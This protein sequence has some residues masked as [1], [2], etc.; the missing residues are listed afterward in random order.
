[1]DQQALRVGNLLVGNS[2]K[3]A[4]VEITLGGFKAEFLCNAH[5]ALTGTDLSPNL[6]GR[7]ISNWAA[8][9]AVS[10][11][12]LALGYARSGLRGYLAFSGGVDVP[13]VMGSRSTYVKGGFGGL[14]GRALTRGDVLPLGETCGKPVLRI[15]AEIIPSYEKAPTLRVIPGPQDDLIASEG[16]EAFFSGYYEVTE[17]LDRM[18]CMLSGKPIRHKGTGDIVTDGTC[19]G[20][21]QV[22]GNGQ[23]IILAADSQTT[24]GYVKIATVISSDLPHV[25]QLSPGSRVRFEPIDFL[26]AREIH[27]KNEFMLRSLYEGRH[28]LR[29][30]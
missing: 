10:G 21:I 13:L 19:P 27:L 18:G 4:T 1:M 17:R 6:N 25:A 16:L 7:P 28:Q 11:D 22:P 3:E 24:G 26:R 20:S 30:G 12:V 5:F 23:P 8:H 29:H 15:P 14:H 9:A 2:D